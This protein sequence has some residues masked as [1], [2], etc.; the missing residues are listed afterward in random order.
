MPSHSAMGTSVTNRLRSEVRAQDD[1]VFFWMTAGGMNKLT[2][3]V[4]NDMNQT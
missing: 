2:L 4:G 3:F 1:S